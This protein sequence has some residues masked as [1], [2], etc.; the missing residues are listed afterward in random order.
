[1]AARIPLEGGKGP[2]L[3]AT[4]QDFAIMPGSK[5]VRFA[6]TVDGDDGLPAIVFVPIPLSKVRTVVRELMA[7]VESL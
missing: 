5:T 3:L 6:L 7:V 4:V 2:F 1:M